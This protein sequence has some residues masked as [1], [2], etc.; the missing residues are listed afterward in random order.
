MARFEIGDKFTRESLSE[1]ARYRRILG[2]DPWSDLLLIVDRQISH[3]GH[4]VVLAKPDCIEYKNSEYEVIALAGLRYFL[5]KDIHLFS[6]RL[7]HTLFTAFFDQLH[8]LQLNLVETPPK[9]VEKFDKKL[10]ELGY[11]KFNDL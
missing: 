6:E 1:Y 2:D 8:Y 4:V 10:R 7:E 5:V 11:R 3:P 9:T